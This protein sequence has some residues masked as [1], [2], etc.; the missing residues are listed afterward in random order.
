MVVSANCNFDI[1]PITFKESVKNGYFTLQKNCWKPEQAVH[2]M[3][4]RRPHILLRSKQWQALHIFYESNVDK[5]QGSKS[6]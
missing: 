3:Q 2:C 4:D 1:N 6:T 5:L